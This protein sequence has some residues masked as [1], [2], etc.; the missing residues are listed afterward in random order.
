MFRPICLSIVLALLLVTCPAP[1]DQ[2]AVAD[3]FQVRQIVEFSE[4]A[5]VFS[6]AGPD[7][8]ESVRL[9]GAAL[10]NIPGAPALPVV[11]LRVALPP[12]MTVNGVRLMESRTQTV[13]GMHLIRPAQPPQVIG[14]G[15]GMPTPVPPDAAIY[16]S[17]EPWPASPVVLSGQADLAG[18]SFAI[19]QVH[20]LRYRPAAGQLTLYGFLEFELYGTDG[21]RCGDYL[22][23]A[24]SPAGRR[25]YE[26]QL[27]RMVVNP[28]AVAPQSAPAAAPLRGVDPG[29][30]DYVIVTQAD[31]VDDFEPLASWRTAT[32]TRS[33]IV[34]TEWIYTSGAY[35]GSA[36]QQL[37]SFVQDVHV[38]WGATHILFGG[39]TDLI[40][41]HFRSVTVP[42]YWTDD[43]PNDTYYAD[44]DGD[45]VCEV[46]TGRASV[47]NTAQIATFI[48]KV[49]TYEQ[50][51]PNKDYL[52]MA[53]FL[54][55][56][57][58]TP[59]DGKGEIE[60]DLLRATH[61]PPGW[62]L[63]T[64]YDSEP[65]THK[66]DMLGYL[67]QGHHLVNHHEHCNWNSMGAG[68]TSHSELITVDDV[69]GL[70]NGNKASI[71]FAIGCWPCD[72][73]YTTSIGEAFLQ[74]EGGGA[75]AFLGNS[76]Y[77]WGAPA[78][79]PVHYSVL[80]DFLLYESLFQLGV[81]DLGDSFCWLKN[82][83]YDPDDPYNLN[84][85]CFTQLYLL[86]DP[87][88]QVWTATPSSTNGVSFPTSITTGSQS[89]TVTV[90]HDGPLDGF[91]VCLWKGEEVYET[92]ATDA[93][94]EVVL[95]IAPSSEG[96]MLVT[97]RREDVLPWQGS[98]QVT[99]GPPET[100]SVGFTAVPQSGT[101]PFTSSLQVTLAN[102]STE[103]RRAAGRID[104]LP[105]SGGPITNW[106]AGWT[107]LAPLEVF[108]TGWNQAFP[109]LATL[110]G[111][112]LFTL[113]GTDVTPPPWN[114]PP[115]A[116][117]GSTD[118]AAF[119]LDC[120]AP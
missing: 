18:Q 61:L 16:R 44:Y 119:T 41:T 95:S 25:G 32:G 15:Q 30:Y 59:G 89:F 108:T 77:G 38:T 102:L 98:C 11:T 3:D 22:S 4:E 78:E 54:G 85:Y 27:K 118:T 94:G 33:A 71:V 80:Q 37:R 97:V 35:I 88:V 101:V 117:S 7:G 52:E 93:S 72:I 49:L 66:A 31:W 43:I 63:N 105:A 73:T 120:T 87:G 115:Y 21:H 8:M 34:T 45:F 29:S 76:R 67:D 106:R 69:N 53:V 40:P 86:G 110:I 111:S 62:V 51:P 64:E 100:L 60:K 84:D 109:A 70:T 20:P 90:D 68:W 47:R 26:S 19:I 12:G 28:E 113:T 58:A 116:P 2:P 104:I 82:M 39:D 9:P 96:T 36:V 17:A 107:N 91:S 75:V 23:P 81:H 42:G 55:F 92:G 74:R 56:D 5:L 114:Q 1:A 65:G 79:D 10:M 48:G 99:A 57:N 6:P 46:A 83:A 50:H 14:G 112:N 13:S 103:N 24:I